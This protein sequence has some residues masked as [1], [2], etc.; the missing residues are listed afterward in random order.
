MKQIR[1]LIVDDSPTVQSV[2]LRMM[3]GEPDIEV[4]GVASDPFEAKRLIMEDKP[5][6]ITLDI[7][8][9]KMDGISFLKRIMSYRPIPVIMISS[10]TQS[11]SLKTLEALEA[12]AIDFITKP[13][14]NVDTKLCELHDEIMSKI[15]AAAEAKVIAPFILPTPLQKIM[16]DMPEIRHKII[17]IGSSIGGPRI[18]QKILSGIFFQP[19]GIVIAQHMAAGYTQAFAQRLNGLIPFEV[20]EAKHLDRIENGKVLIAP[21][22]KNMIVVRNGNDFTIR[23][24]N[25]P[26]N[27]LHRPSVD[28]LFHSVAKSVGSDAVGIILSGMG[29]DGAEGLHAMKQAGAFTIA[30]EKAGCVVFGMPQSAI[31]RGGVDVVASPDNIP[32]LICENAKKNSNS[33][34]D[35]HVYNNKSK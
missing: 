16:I 31:K 7:E 33:N 35:N 4:I 20:R 18:I 9:P 13:S 10:Y 1:V 29:E 34:N 17:A 14:R 24:D 19:R 25:N 28:V 12:G 5:D 11:N 3:S 27:T 21:G 32:N 23:I 6:V 26:K 15:R 30:Q 22:G 2:L 8:M